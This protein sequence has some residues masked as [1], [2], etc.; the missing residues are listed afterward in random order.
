MSIIFR[1]ALCAAA[2]VAAP[3]AQAAT[4]AEGFDPFAGWQTRWFGANSNAANYYVTEFGEESGYQGAADVGG[5]YLSD[6]DNYTATGD[7]QSIGIRFSN[8]FAASLT[9]FGFDIATE[10]T[11]LQL[12]FVDLQG[13]SL[14]TF[15]VQTSGSVSANGTPVGYT[16]YGITSTRGIGGFTITSPAQGSVIVDN[17][18]AVTAA[19]PEPTTWQMMIL[20][21]GAVGLTLRRRRVSVRFA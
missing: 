12:T 10:L 5:L 17:L 13:A 14:G 3:A 11:G 19:I 18:R 2:L 15:G 20:G 21:F 1:A 8:A 9:E 16:S 7:Y 6:G 4:F